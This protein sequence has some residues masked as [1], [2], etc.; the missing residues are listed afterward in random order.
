MATTKFVLSKSQSQKKNKSNLSMLMLRYSHQKKVTYFTT[1]KNIEDKYW[2]TKNQKIKRSYPGS[3]R[4]NILINK[5]KQKVEDISNGILI[6]GGN[7]IPQLVKQIYNQDRQ[8]ALKKTQYTFFEY[9]EVFI[10]NS[11]KHKKD[12]TIKTYKTTI[13]RLHDYEKFAR[14][15]LDWSSFDIDFYYDLMEYYTEVLRL[16]NNGFGRLIKVLKAIL[17]DATE[18]GYNTNL[19][20]KHK[21]FKAVREEVNTIYLNENELKAIINLDLSDN[22]KLDKVRDLFIVGCYTGLRFSDFSEIKRENIIGNMLKVKTIKTD[23]WVTIPLLEPVKAVLKKYDHKINCFPKSFINQTMN[24]H[25]KE[26]ARRAWINDKVLKTRNRGKTRVE[27]SFAKSKLVTTHTARRS[28]ATNMFKRGIPSRVIMAITG[29]TTERAFTS[30]I[31][32]SRDENAELMLRYLNNSTD[33][34]LGN[35]KNQ[36]PQQVIL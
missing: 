23:Q 11:K 29:H 12:G 27:E 14:V 10:E 32:I 18:K 15:K 16:T 31:K 8:V 3:D 21:G 7:P 17:N 25:L 34:I 33:G 13:N 5:L 26:I 2:D 30:Y 36:L 1:S 20:F 28:F 19:K 35:Y 22:P 4:L 6:Q 24:K 9:A